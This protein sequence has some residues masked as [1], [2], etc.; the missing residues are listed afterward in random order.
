MKVILAAWGVLA[1]ATLIAL[2]APP[3]AALAAIPF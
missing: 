3:A 2:A 1:L